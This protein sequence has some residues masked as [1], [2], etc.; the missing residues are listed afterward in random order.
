[1]KMSVFLLFPYIFN[2]S[3]KIVL[4][5][6]MNIPK[7]TELVTNVHIFLDKIVKTLMTYV[8]LEVDKVTRIKKPI[9]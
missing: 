3:H 4:N 1:M 7:Q 8:F 5:M 6:K 9:I 2:A